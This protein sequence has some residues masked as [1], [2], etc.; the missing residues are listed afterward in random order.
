VNPDTMRSPASIMKLVTTWAALSE[1]GPNFVWQT[2][3]LTDA[4]AT[5]NDKGVLSGPLY[6]R[7]EGDP[8]F[9][10]ED[11]WR[12]LR[13]LRL[14]GIK[15]IGDIV[16]DRSLFADVAIDPG[17]FDGKPDRPYNASPDVFMVGFGSVRIVF[18]PDMQNSRWKAF[19]DPRIPGIDV[20]S[21]VRWLPGPCRSS[22]QIDVERVVTA[23]QVRYR[24][25]GQAY[26][27]CGEF[28]MY[29]LAFDQQT[30]A[31]KVM[32]AMWTELGG[33]MTGEVIN[34]NIPK[35]AIPVAAYQSPPLSEVIRYINKRSNNVMTRVLLLTL[36]AKSGNRPATVAAGVSRIKAILQR[37]GLD[38]SSAV[39][40][41]GSGLS[42]NARLSANQLASMLQTAWKAPAMPEFMSSLAILGVDGTLQ[43]RLTDSKTRGYA[44]MK[45]GALKD[46]RSIAG[47]VLSAS[48]DRYIFVSIVNHPDAHKAREF[49]NDIMRWLIER[50]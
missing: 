19:V 20:D 46:T 32:K 42:R 12:L 13:D 35:D 25:T 18:T 31:S 29:R 26:G 45:T 16:I 50:K 15:Q 23:S 22:P 43:R 2:V 27:S 39:I 17:E 48:G 1:L 47:Y 28:D 4:K 8:M 10:L 36:A 41:N 44:Y 14:R 5:V 11:L 33:V 24:V 7:P 9:M 34:G 37:Q 30:M 40:E 3:L 6:L 49:E 38:F 21:E